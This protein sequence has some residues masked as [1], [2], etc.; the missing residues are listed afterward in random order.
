MG[1]GAMLIPAGMFHP[2]GGRGGGGGGTGAG[3]TPS[4]TFIRQTIEFTF[5]LE[6]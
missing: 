2:G 4:T 5:V 6:S 3:S 1:T